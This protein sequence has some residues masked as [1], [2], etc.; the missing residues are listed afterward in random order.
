M[1]AQ[2]TQKKLSNNFSHTISSTTDT[3]TTTNNNEIINNN[4]PL[5]GRTSTFD[6]PVGTYFRKP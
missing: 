2:G 1:K 3:N 5:N 4:K 6:Q